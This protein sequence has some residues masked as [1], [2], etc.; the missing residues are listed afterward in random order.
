MKIKNNVD[1]TCYLG[2]VFLLI[3]FFFI[4]KE[5]GKTMD[6]FSIFGEERKT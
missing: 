4:Q 1:F 3:R 2:F 5:D 6:L